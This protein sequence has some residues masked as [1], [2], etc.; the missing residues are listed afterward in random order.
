MTEILAE[1]LQQWIG[2]AGVVKLR[3]D[4][5]TESVS[6]LSKINRQLWNK[7]QEENLDM[8][9]LIAEHKKKQLA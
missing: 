1:L 2:Q 7:C 5:L 3:S 8:N 6:I 4:R 9:E